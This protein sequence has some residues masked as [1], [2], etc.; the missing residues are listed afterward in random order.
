MMKINKKAP[1]TELFYFRN[2]ENKGLQ[3]LPD[4]VVTKFTM[5]LITARARKTKRRILPISIDIPA[6]P[7][8]PNIK[9]TS[10]RI[11]NAMAAL[12]M[13]TSSWF[14]YYEDDGGKAKAHQAFL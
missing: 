13:L 9:A 3:R 12:N 2:N 5:K 10:A 8:A 14:F 11:K 6:M 1:E 7:D 4:R